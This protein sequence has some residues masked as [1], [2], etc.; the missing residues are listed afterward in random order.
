MTTN[1]MPLPE[2]LRRQKTRIANLRES[3]TELRLAKRQIETMIDSLVGVPSDVLVQVRRELEMSIK[4]DESLLI[5]DER[6]FENLLTA[7]A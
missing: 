1:T 4:R 6:E 3:L 2:K 5:D 7:I